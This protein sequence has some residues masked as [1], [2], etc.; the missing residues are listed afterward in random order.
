MFT[1]NLLTFTDS[2]VNAE[3]FIEQ[4]TWAELKNAPSY[5]LTAKIDIKKTKR[6]YVKKINNSIYHFE[7]YIQMQ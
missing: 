1:E 7:N 4:A 5:L 2:L 3:N 6:N